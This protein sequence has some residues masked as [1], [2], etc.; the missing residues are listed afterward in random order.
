MDS[1]EPVSDSG[2]GSYHLMYKNKN[3]KTAKDVEDLISKFLKSL[4]FDNDN[5]FASI[6]IKVGNAARITKLYGTVSKK[7][8]NTIERPHRESKIVKVPQEI[9]KHRLH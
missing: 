6:D 8:A 4:N 2:N 9:N 1:S 5:D 3:L 7:G